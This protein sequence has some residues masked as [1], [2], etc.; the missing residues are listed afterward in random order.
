MAD[1]KT[2]TG[3]AESLPPLRF[4]MVAEKVDA[5]VTGRMTPI[6]LQADRP[7]S[8]HGFAGRRNAQRALD[9]NSFMWGDKSPPIQSIK[10][11]EK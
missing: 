10:R 9:G 8:G 3:G 2:H 6:I 11:I 1:E 5:M 4:W 7:L